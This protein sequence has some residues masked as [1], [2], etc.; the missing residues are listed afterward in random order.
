MF[1]YVSLPVTMRV[2]PTISTKSGSYG[3]INAERS[4]TYDIT[5]VHISHGAN[6]AETE[7][8][9][10]S[11]FTS[12]VVT[13]GARTA[14]EGVTVMHDKGNDAFYFDAEL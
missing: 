6:E 12:T 9:G 3:N 13:S 10:C 14:G 1:V 8:H 5:N 4:D 11:S 2:T 7:L